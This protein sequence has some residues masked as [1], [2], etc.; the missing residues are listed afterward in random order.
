M[1]LIFDLTVVRADICHLS[2]MAFGK[3]SQT[4]TGRWI[5]LFPGRDDSVRRFA[6]LT[7]IF[8][9]MSKLPTAAAWSLHNCPFQLTF[10]LDVPE[11]DHTA[12]LDIRL[13]LAERHHQNCVSGSGDEAHPSAVG[14]VRPATSWRISVEGGSRKLVHIKRAPS[15][16]GFLRAYHGCLDAAAVI[17]LHTAAA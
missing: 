8:V 1:L 7:E 11:P 4:E 10:S 3:V 17:L 9:G 6:S 14:I 13:P 2:H 15:H 16:N 12:V 5:L